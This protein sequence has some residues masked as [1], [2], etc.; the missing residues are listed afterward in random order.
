MKSCDK[1]F[2]RLHFSIKPKGVFGIACLNLPVCI[3]FLFIIKFITE[4]VFYI[5][6]GYGFLLKKCIYYIRTVTK[7]F[8]K[9]FW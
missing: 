1:K 6:I 9:D 3:E 2:E 4:F 7:I 8:T 5:N